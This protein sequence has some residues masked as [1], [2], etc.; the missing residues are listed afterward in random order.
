MLVRA[1]GDGDD[2]ARDTRRF[3]SRCS[4]SAV[5]R[6]HCHDHAR[7][8]GVV[9]SERQHVVLF[10]TLG[11]AAERQIKNVHSVLDRG[12]NR[13][14]DILAA[15]VH[16]VTRADIVIP[17]PGARSNA[18]HII[19]AY[20]VHKGSFAGYSSRYASSVRAVILNCLRVA[21]LLSGLVKKDLGNND[22]WRDVLAI[23]VFLVRKAISRIALGE[24]RRI[25]EA[26]RI[27]ER[28]RLINTRIDV[29]DFDT[30][31][32]TGSATRSI[33]GTGRI[34]DAVALAQ[35]GMIEEVV[36]GP[37]HHRRRGDRR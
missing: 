15:S 16:H 10:C 25:A 17:N 1:R 3:N 14:E 35:A 30:G 22:F 34:D 9:E 6:C 13:P 19:D 28:M 5:A 20:A 32:G 11:G 2:F 23:L 37:P 18:G 27:E 29:A 4:G 33:P 26:S 36:L 12:L 24:A 7:I 21:A 31:A 8:D